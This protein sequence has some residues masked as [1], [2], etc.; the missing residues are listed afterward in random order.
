[1]NEEIDRKIRDEINRRLAS[2]AKVNEEYEE[3]EHRVEVAAEVA[4]APAA[5][6]SV[7]PPKNELLSII[8][9]DENADKK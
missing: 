5:A 3:V 8:D 9:D 1:M 7:S 2:G 4:V 6:T